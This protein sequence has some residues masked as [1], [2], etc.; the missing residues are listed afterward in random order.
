[1]T[2]SSPDLLTHLLRDVSRSFYRTLRLV[3]ARV[4][5]Q[6]GVAYLLARATD[7]IADTDVL[8][9][10][11]RL[12]ALTRLRERILGSESAPLE[13]P[14]LAAHQALHAEAVLLRRIEEVIGVL[15][16]FTCFDRCCVREVLATITSGQELDLRRFEGACRER[17]LCLSTESELEDYT[18]RV[19]GCVGNFWTRLCRSHLYPEAPLD[20][21]RYLEDAV[22]FGRGLQRV[23]ILRDLPFD[24]RKGRCYLPAE[25][26]GEHG[27][28]AE[29]L[30]D[31]AV[32]RRFR[33]LY[34]AHLER[35]S[36]DLAAGWRYTC[37]TPRKQMRIRVACALPILIGI[38]TLRLLAN[39]NI[40]DASRRIKISRRRVRVLLLRSLMCHPFPRAWEGLFS[41]DLPGGTEAA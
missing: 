31:P 35:A 28:K 29:D 40:L 5:P 24:L 39:A 19:A 14:V 2:A 8:P 34:M 22:S 3:P 13:L 6:I 26:L 9:L 37:V 33:P 20:L 4:R 41:P 27:L 36:S 18:F 25:G 10:E 1:M 38:E 12:D 32:H 11:E 17:V 30:L 21:P 23:N 7:T 15:S 16:R